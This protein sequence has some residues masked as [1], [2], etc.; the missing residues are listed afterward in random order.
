MFTLK[1]V[2]TC[3]ISYLKRP[4][5]FG[6]NFSKLWHTLDA[7]LS[8]V[9]YECHAWNSKI[10]KVKMYARAISLISDLRRGRI[11]ITVI[12]RFFTM[13]SPSSNKENYSDGCYSPSLPRELNIYS[14]Q[15]TV[16]SKCSNR[17]YRHFGISPG[18]FSAS[19]INGI[20][21]HT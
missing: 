5:L 21:C 14:Q 6:Y 13:S 20:S 7:V 12:P 4:L 17:M 2:S 11:F 1:S 3:P 19:D 9:V 16:K 10:M 15:T 8:E 18:S